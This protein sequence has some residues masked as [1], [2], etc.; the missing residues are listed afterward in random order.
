[1]NAAG[2]NGGERVRTMISFLQV[3]NE[4]NI[5]EVF[6]WANMAAKDSQSVSFVPSF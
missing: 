6:C 4:Y 2:V 1:M 5:D 3:K